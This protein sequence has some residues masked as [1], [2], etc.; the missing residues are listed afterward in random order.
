MSRIDTLK[1]QFPSLSY[2]IFDILTEIDGTKT[3]KY[4]QFLCKAYADKISTQ[5][6]NGVTKEI[7]YHL[8]ELDIPKSEND[9]VNYIKCRLSDMFMSRNDIKVFNQFKSHM[10]NGYIE[11][12]DI[13]KYSNFSDISGAVSLAELKIYEKEMEN[14]VVKEFEDDNW[15]IVRPLSFKS[16]C[17][18]GAGTKW[19][20]TFSDEKQYF[21]K[22]FFESTLIYI[23]NKKTGYKVA[24][25]GIC[26]QNQLRDVSFWT[27]DDDRKDFLELDIDDYLIDVIRKIIKSN[28]S[29]SSF[30]SKSELLEI[31]SECRSLYRLDERSELIKER[32]PS[33]SVSYHDPIQDEVPQVSF[34]A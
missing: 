8:N 3:H 25:H 34:R 2:S 30:V 5:C 6:D 33:L 28:I 1:K 7:T 23:I 9:V 32:E 18:Y 19:C 17:K 22:Y 10:E 11:N 4:L 13:T 21:F 15:I 27:A 24:M 31:A 16:S 29:N 26:F 20:T 12:N 14:N